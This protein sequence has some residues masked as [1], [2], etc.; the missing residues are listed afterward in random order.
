M[1]T[2]VDKP[3]LTLPALTRIVRDELDRYYDTL[4]ENMDRIDTETMFPNLFYGAFHV[5]KKQVVQKNISETKKFDAEW[6]K[7]ME[8]YFPYIDKILK[9][10]KSTIRYDREVV[11]VE[12]AKKTDSESVRH[13]ASHSQFVS[14][15]NEETGFVKPKK[16][17]TKHTEQEM[18]IYENRFIMTLINRCFFFV[19]KRLEIIRENVESWQKDYLSY[20]NEFKMKENKV[21]L[22]LD[23][24]IMKDLDNTSINLANQ[25]LLKRAEKLGL[26]IGGYRNSPLMVELKNAKE[27]RPPI[28]KTNIIMK[29]PD[30]KM[31]YKL[32]TFLDKYNLLPFELDIKERTLSFDEGF[33]TAMSKASIAFYSIV[34]ANQLSRLELYNDI[35]TKDFKKKSTYEK[36]HTIV[37]T[38]DT[39]ESLKTE[40]FEMNEYYLN[41]LS[42]K[43][44]ADV[45][46]G[47]EQGAT[48]ET[49][50]RR[51]MK[52]TLAITNSLYESVFRMEEDKED[53][54]KLLKKD[55]DLREEIEILK[56]QIKVAKIIREVKQA[57]YNKSLKDEEKLLKKLGEH[58]I[59]YINSEKLRK[60]QEASKIKQPVKKEK[61]TKTMLS[62]Q[63]KANKAAID[64]T[65]ANDLRIDRI[66]DKNLL[67][68]VEAKRAKINEKELER[69]NKEN[70]RA[71]LKK[72]KEQ[73]AKMK[74]K[75]IA[76][77][78]LNVLKEKEKA[79]VLKEKEKAKEKEKVLRD[80]EKA[81]EKEKQDRI[82]AKQ[83]AKD[84][85]AALKE[86][87]K[88][89]QK[90]KKSVT[91]PVKNSSSKILPVVSKPNPKSQIKKAKSVENDK[92]IGSEPKA[93]A[94]K[95]IVNL[96]IKE[97]NIK[98]NVVKNDIPI[99]LDLMS[100]DELAD[101]ILQSG[102][103]MGDEN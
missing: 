71:R 88:Q 21:T 51:A 86:K 42:E 36:K 58:Q 65:L 57:D 4:I 66:Q 35:A 92:K 81:K 79:K 26:M 62:S 15:I 101:L 38:D 5:G 39:P 27:V 80:K 46:E 32:W 98:P 64:E 29:N 20:T 103:G 9:N 68:I 56:K 94:K 102:K 48:Y 41:K 17:L 7:N 1:P 97:Q 91:K 47:R 22:K 85:L 83:K 84:K 8:I 45:T 76:K 60:K 52:N 87:N 23:L 19:R 72:E 69:I 95:P 30:F 77:A 12:R 11:P 24:E 40:D 3:K 96:P 13:L 16:I 54:S 37:N 31:A 44:E 61:L 25:E 28:L 67:E 6:I 33:D 73:D 99:D 82:K 78:K 90:S 53:Y 75:Q 18:G 49:S 10:P 34:L 70:E 100:S 2:K 93:G 89:A 43:F 14:E 55:K 63:I 50:L 59:K 74:E